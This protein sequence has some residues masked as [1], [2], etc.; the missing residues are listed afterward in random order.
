MK[1]TTRIEGHRVSW[2]IT[3]HRVQGYNGEYRTNDDGEGMWHGERQEV[4]TC[5][6][7]LRHLTPAA[8][9]AKIRRAF[10]LAD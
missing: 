10:T 3:N 8:I 6:F 9:R 1:I 4:G 7:T 5:D 2:T